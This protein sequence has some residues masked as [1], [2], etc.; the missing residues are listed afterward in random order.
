MKNDTGK[1]IE[2]SMSYLN[3][4]L[5]MINVVKAI[6]KCF[7]FFY[8][9]IHPILNHIPVSVNTEEQILKN[10]K[11]NEYN[12]KGF[13]VHKYSGIY[14]HFGYLL[15]SIQNLVNILLCVLKMYV[16]K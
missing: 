6:W 10:R 3:L 8:L 15:F 13:F 7:L 2:I 16:S 12:I 11:R 4:D 5:T 14:F 1:E 9:I